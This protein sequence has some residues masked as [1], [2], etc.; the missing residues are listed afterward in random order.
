MDFF[1]GKVAPFAYFEAAEAY[2]TDSD[3]RKLQD[4]YA[5]RLTHSSYLSVS[6]LE[7]LELR[8]GAAAFSF[9]DL[10]NAHAHGLLAVYLDRL[11]QHS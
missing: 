6:A 9:A 4:L 1:L 7:K 10:G 11:A 5:V 3:A 8:H 2:L